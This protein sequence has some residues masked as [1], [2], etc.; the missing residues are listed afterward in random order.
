MIEDMTPFKVNLS[1]NKAKQ[2]DNI[3][4]D[5]KFNWW[6][7]FST[8]SDTHFERQSFWNKFKELLVCFD[9]RFSDMYL[10]LLSFHIYIIN[11]YANILKIRPHLKWI[12]PETKQNRQTIFLM[13]LNLIDDTSLPPTLTLIFYVNVLKIWPNFN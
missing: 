5:F 9:D 4:N 7:L 2:T 11:F 8:H 10:L 13:I 12:C 1:R 6:Y 3:P